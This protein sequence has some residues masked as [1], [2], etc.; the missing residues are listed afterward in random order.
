MGKIKKVKDKYF[1]RPG[2][3]YEGL[4][5]IRWKSVVHGFIQHICY[6]CLFIM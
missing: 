3:I 2:K 5:L 4:L 6:V 1:C